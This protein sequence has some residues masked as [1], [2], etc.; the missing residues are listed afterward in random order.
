MASLELCRYYPTGYNVKGHMN[1]ETQHMKLMIKLT[2][3]VGSKYNK[4]KDI[5]LIYTHTHHHTP[6]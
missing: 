6:L 5:A 1:Y 4:G 2:F 3:N